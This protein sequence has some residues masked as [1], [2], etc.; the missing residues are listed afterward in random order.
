MKLKNFIIFLFFILFTSA[1]S[2]DLKL[3]SS[4]NSSV[5]FEYKP[6]YRDTSFVIANGQQ[7]IKIKFLGGKVENITQ[8]GMPQSSVKEFNIGVPSEFGNTIQ[9]LSEDYSTINGKYLPVPQLL[10]DSLSYKDEYIEA[11]NYNENRFTE[12]VTFGEYGL[13]RNLPV[14]TIK[15]YPVQFDAFSNSIRLLKRIIFKINYASAAVRKQK[16][17]DD[18]YQY[19]VLNWDVAKNWGEPESRLQKISSSLL[20][21]GVWYRFETAEEGIY[22]IDRTFLQNL[23]IDL[24]T[25]DPKT[26]KIYGNGG[27]AL[28]EELSKS[29]N[30]GLIENTVLAVGEDDGKFD[31]SDYI[32]FYGRP[33]E[34][35][36]YDVLSRKILRVKNPYSKKNYYWLTFG[37]ANGKRMSNKA[38]LNIQGAFQQP[39]TIAFKSYEKDSTN[40]GSTG[41]EYFGDQL[42]VSLK[43]RTYINSLNGIVP[44]TPVYYKFRVV[45]ASE[46]RISFQVEE[47]GTRIYSS[48]LYGTVQYIYGR[49]DIGTAAYFGQLANERSVLRLS[50][51]TDSKSAKVFL[52]YFEI[53]Y[54]KLLKA[55]NDNLLFFSKDTTAAIEYTLSNFSNSG[56]Q[57]FDVTD[58]ANVKLITNAAISGGQFKFQMSEK[59]NEVKKYLALISSQY[60][61]PANPLKIENSNIREN[62]T[63][64][65]LVVITTKELKT[66]VDRYANYRANQSPNKI[67]TSVFYVDEIMNEFS[68]GLLDPTAI[69]DFLKFAYESWQTKPFYLLLFGDGTYDYLNTVKDNKNLVPTYQT[70]ES[71]DAIYSSVMDDYY[72]RIVGDDRKADLAVGRLNVNSLKEAEV[73]ID[74]I[75]KYEMQSDKGSWKNIISLVADDAFASKGEYEGSIHT[76]QSETL[77]QLI[78][79]SFDLNK[80]YLAAYPTFFSGLGRRKPEVN[81]AIINAINDGTLILNFTGHGNPELWTHEV[82]FEKSASIPQLKNNNYF[83]LTAATCDFGRYDDPIEQSATENLMLLKNSGTIGAFTAARVVYASDNAEINEMF[84]SNIFRPRE[85][86]ILPIRIGK[87]YFFTKQIRTNQNDEKFHLFGDPTIRLDMPQLPVNI[88]SLNGRPVTSTVQINALGQVKI[89]GTVRKADGTINPLNGEALISVYDS[90]R[91]LELKEMNYSITL[92]GGLIFRGKASVSNGNFNTD[93]VVPKDISYENKRGKVISY[94]YN[95]S[96]DGIGF[97]NNVIVGGTNPNAVNDGKGPEIQIFFDDLK[98]ESSYLVNKDFLLLVKLSDQTGLNTTGTGIGHKLEGI[99]NDDENNTY[100]FTN[101]FV[102]DLNS[103]GR[104]GLIKYQF[105]DKEP[106]DYKI[107]IKAWDVFNNFS[108]QAAYFTVISADKG[109][110]IRNL[111]NYPNP[112][113]SNTTFTFQNN[114]S[115][116]IDVKIKIYTIAGRMIKQLEVWNLLDRFVRID[117]DGRDADGNQ[118][119]NGTYLYKLIVDSADGKYKESVLGKLSVIR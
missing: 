36:E 38:S 59:R 86:G 97:T 103:G 84:Y 19:L 9:I 75:I 46:P 40:L 5:V 115:S 24:N 68:G 4:N 10:K 94:I 88:D 57:T 12:T 89:K 91:S 74:K 107:K 66:Q 30:T 96:I 118:L 83:F 48:T 98:F 64:S 93:F 8:I 17:E 60:K 20:P 101:S 112:F 105:N 73:V 114:I 21:S 108:S 81:K 11:D 85:N 62:L 47:S 31:A 49:D 2:Q 7:Y 87:A 109:I 106:G 45:N 42:D 119:A 1:V 63:G 65:E 28:P 110:V 44:S 50:I 71:L 58:F 80:I 32:L 78:P 90:E 26:I 69:R 27:Y 72:S 6:F 18:T 116:P 13:V 100:D 92:Q 102:G 99:I 3:L 113:S 117:W 111:V 16:I 77:A 43:S 82:V 76:A 33:H 79:S 67:S 95:E 15:I 25:L 56:I 104:S 61:T 29:K 51:Q 39:N 37:G 34:F 14:Q 55:F 54:Q 22:R 52:D 70:V 35:W 41:R 23:G 53:T